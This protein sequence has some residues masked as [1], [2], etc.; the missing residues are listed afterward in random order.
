L[1]DGRPR[2]AV[3]TLTARRQPDSAS[4]LAKESADGFPGLRVTLGHGDVPRTIDHGQL[5][6]QRLR[7]GS[8]VRG[9]KDRISASAC[10][11]AWDPNRGEPTTSGVAPNRPLRAPQVNAKATQGKSRMR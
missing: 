7:Q 5:G 6:A 9:W 10:D 1:T 8:G 11:E 4:E 3:R 2:T